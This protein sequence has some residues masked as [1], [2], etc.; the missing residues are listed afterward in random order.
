MSVVFRCRSTQ[1]LSDDVLSSVSL[2]LELLRVLL[3]CLVIGRVD[4]H[5]PASQSTNGKDSKL[6]HKFESRTLSFPKPFVKA[7]VTNKDGV[8]LLV[9]LQEVLGERSKRAV[10]VKEEEQGAEEEGEGPGGQ[11]E[12]EEEE[13]ILGEF[14][15]ET[16]EVIEE[17]EGVVAD[18]QGTA[19]SLQNQSKLFDC[20]VIGLPSLEPELRPLMHSLEE[21]Y[22]IRS[23]GTTMENGT[24]R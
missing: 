11:G 2:F 20:H 24:S 12:E 21:Q 10:P 4:T 13:R 8:D 22:E 5:T 9:Q 3:S 17:L 1:P 6:V 15:S 16:G 7:L 19:N 14:S 23:I 18:A